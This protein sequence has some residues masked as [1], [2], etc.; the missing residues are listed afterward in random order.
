MAGRF[1]WVK[2]R[3]I[4]CGFAIYGELGQHYREQHMPEAQRQAERDKADQYF[5][6][7]FYDL[8]Y[9]TG[10]NYEGKVIRG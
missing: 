2:N 1:H 4:Y 7:I 5:S 10:I 3:C 8:A 9:R 6:E